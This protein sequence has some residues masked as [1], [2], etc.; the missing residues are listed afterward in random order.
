MSKDIYTALGV[1]RRINAAGT[2]TRLGAAASMTRWGIARMA[3]LPHTDGFVNEI[4]L[5]CTHYTGYAHALRAS[6]TSPTM[7]AAPA[8]EYAASRLGGS[9]WSGSPRRQ[10][11]C[12]TLGAPRRLG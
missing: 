5:H 12:F 11:R 4:L 9:N 1:K 3:A 6:S 2:L 7:T 10:A 8:P